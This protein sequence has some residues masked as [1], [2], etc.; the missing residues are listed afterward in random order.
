MKTVMRTVASAALAAVAVFGVSAQNPYAG[1]YDV[2]RM[3]ARPAYRQGQVIVKFKTEG[4]QT[5]TTLR[6]SKSG[7]KAQA[8][9]ATLNGLLDKYGASEAEELMPLTGAKVTPMR[10]LRKSLN[11]TIV[12]DQ[13][14]SSLYLLRL[15]TKK[16][17][18]LDEVLESFRAL[19]E[20]D[21]AE[22]NYLVYA[23]SSG[24]AATYSSDPLYSQ[25]WG[26]SA[27]NLDKLW[28]EPIINEKRPVIAILDT[29]VDIAHPDLADNIW[30][31]ALESDGAEGSDDDGNGFID[32]VHGWDFVNQSA[33]MRDNNGHGTHC[34]GIAA[35]IGGNG[36]GIAGANPNALIMPIT[37]MQSDGTGDVGTIIKGIDYARANGADVLSM[38]FGSTSHSL[39]E[40][41]AL[42]KAYQNAVLVAAAGNEDSDL[43]M[44]H[45]SPCPPVFPGAYNFVIGVMASDPDNYRAGFSNWDCDG[46]LACGPYNNEQL[47]SYEV[48]A[49]GTN[50]VSTYPGGGYRALNGTSM[51]TP[52][53]AGAISRLYQCKDIPS[54]ELLFGDMVHT[55]QGGL[56]LGVL[57]I[58]A[59]YK[60][61]DADRTP[62]LAMTTYRI[63]D[64]ADG[65]GDLRAD[66]GETFDIYPTVR[67]FWGQARNVT[68]S[69]ELAENEDPEIVELITPTVEFGSELSSYSLDESKNPLRIKI[70]DNCV[71]GRK[72]SLVIKGTCDN[73]TEPF[74]QPVVLTVENGIELSG[75]IAHDMTLYPDK[76]YIVTS[77]LGIPE[78]VTLTLMP[79]AVLKFKDNTG[80]SVGLGE[81]TEIDGIWDY[82]NAGRIIAVGTPDKRIVFTKADLDLG[83]NH[84]I[85]VQNNSILKYCEITGMDF[86]TE[87]NF[88]AQKTLMSYNTLNLEAG[89]FNNSSIINNH[90]KSYPY[91]E[92]GCVSHSTV[93]RNND[94]Y[95]SFFLFNE[96]YV[97]GGN[98]FGNYYDQ[99]D[100]R[101][102]KSARA[103]SPYAYLHTM[104]KPS[105][106]GSARKDILREWVWDI[107]NPYNMTM[108]GQT[109][110]ELD[111]SNMLTRPDAEAP[112][113]V[114]KVVVDGYD[115]QDEFE[116]LPDLGVG[117]HKFE[118]YF[119]KRMNRAKTPMVAMGVRPPYTQ[120]AIADSGSWREE[121]YENGDTIDIYTAYLDIKGSDTFDGL[122][123]LYVA[124]AEDIEYFPVPIED[125]RFHVNVQSAGS[126]S[127]G[128]VAEAGI[129]QVNLSWDSP[130]EY[131]DDMLGYN[132]YRYTLN[133]NFEP[134]DTIR[135]NEDVLTTE[136]FTDYDIT[137]GTTYNYYYKVIRTSL[138]ENSPSRVVSATPR[139]AGKGDADASGAVDVADVVTEVNYMVGRNPKPFMFEAADINDDAE[140]DILDVVGTVNIILRPQSSAA[141]V[142]SAATYC[143]I[144]GVVYVDS[145]VELAGV[146]MQLRGE[147]GRTEIAVL[148]ALKGM[149]ST[150]AWITSDEYKF[151]AFSLSGNSVAA[152]RT[153][154]LNIGDATLDDIILVDC[155]GKR[156]YALNES[157][158]GIGAVTMEQMRAPS[159]NPF[160][161]ELNV[162]V[163]LGSAGSHYVEFA[164]TSLDGRAAWSKTL[165]LDQ[166]CHTVTLRPQGI[167]SGFYLLT[168][169]VDGK[170]V[171]S[172]KVIKK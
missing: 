89:Y 141:S 66:A 14:L 136:A 149:E 104:E 169:I 1:S 98:F 146:Q 31:N 137:P 56:I 10:K 52:L 85:N 144:D 45:V 116:M 76:H 79:G 100:K 18:N 51:A 121:V 4:V 166:G 123:R 2:N 119:S 156:V 72:I 138:S 46:P 127:A 57:D 94:S 107:K 71:D 159:P 114:W 163:T 68:L 32:D 102:Y 99:Y 44:C 11:G 157:T 90:I 92:P 34:A 70:N 111:L 110:V 122:N 20:V 6:K 113:C 153:A 165:V 54:K 171:Q 151:V 91:S 131:F 27:I 106:L 143:V 135:I 43:N 30:T 120:I 64:T 154:L 81:R 142:S 124:E 140:V 118:V 13:D 60:V 129:G 50:I 5:R 95:T 19:P 161:E 97:E 61:S 48:M 83:Q 73:I 78:G 77:M 39:A 12:K 115:A 96:N 162:P 63:D 130:E 80:I 9:A 117:R 17:A 21:Y 150:G 53:V 108:G 134:G 41:D 139:A 23:C 87:R 133:E 33:R 158:S 128:F 58:E 126:M 105:Y 74:E 36:I 37:V 62:T 38:S 147:A 164:L 59:L 170:A 132:L 103:Y 3:D 93:T 145:P 15:D 109:A 47:Y 35:A 40:Y 101:Y 152:G 160:E 168:M 167:A 65:D 75:I 86:R 172:C 125:F 16:A 49:P 26:I 69:I 42:A 88:T 112:G 29:G 82:Y 7:V 55:L 25:Q 155:D 22:P 67:N 84:V 148:P 28:N 8:S 24:N